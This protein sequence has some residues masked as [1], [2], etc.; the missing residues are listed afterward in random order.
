MILAVLSSLL[1]GQ[2]VTQPPPAIAFD[3]WKKVA[4]SEEALEY[5]LSFPSA[6]PTAYPEN[7]LVQVRAIVPSQVKGPMPVVVLLHYL[8]A[9]DL[10]IERSIADEL[11][12]GGMG[13]VM[14]TLP[15][16]MARTP[17][18]YSSGELAIQP[19]PAK[20]VET[21]TQSVL[22]VR[23]TL[24][25]IASRP[26]F[27]QSKIGVGGTSLGALVGSLV[28]A[29]DARV[30]AATF[31][32]SGADLAHILWNSSRVVTQRDIMR[33]RGY[34]EQRLREALAVI[35]PLR[36]LPAR[37]DGSSFVIGARY[38]T[39]IPPSDTLK[40]IGALKNPKVLWL[41][42]GHYGGAFVQ[43][44]LLKTVAKFFVEELS[45]REFRPPGRIYAPTIRIGVDLNAVTGLQVAAGLDLWRD[46][47][48][49]NSFVSAMLTPRGAELFVGRRLDKGLALG[50][51]FLARGLSPGLFWSTVL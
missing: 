15:Y 2:E 45:G 36:Y 16:H 44:K 27:D 42:T 35:E 48:R 7:S 20:L 22:D 17:K 14:V 6:Y 28:F 24:D 30:R 9:T 18:G 3:A 4:E 26:E 1:R 43:R 12:K 10:K 33:S 31:M 21:M 34:T 23:R 41:E 19:D 37:T 47:G 46:E 13:A 40:L 39:V 25:W 51:T 11:A 32:L 49:T 50:I 38:D 29:L 8:G 5:S